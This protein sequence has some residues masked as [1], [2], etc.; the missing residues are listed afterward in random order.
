MKGAQIGR[1]RFVLNHLFF[2]YECVLFSDASRANA[3]VV[4]NL[5]LEYESVSGQEVN[6]DK[7]LIFFGS[8]VEAQERDAVGEVLGVRIVQDPEK[9]LGL[10]MMVG[11]QKRRAFLHHVDRFRKRVEGWSTRFLSVGGRRSS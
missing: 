3:Q 8:N 7:S 2:A 1:E 10:P 6:F 9:Y 5:V 4:C 11:R